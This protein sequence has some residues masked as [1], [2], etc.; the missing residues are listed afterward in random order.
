MNPP[1]PHLW[2]TAAVRGRWMVL[3]PGW[4]TN[5]T[6]ICPYP[7]QKVGTMQ[8]SIVPKLLPLQHWSLFTPKTKINS[9]MKTCRKWKI[10]DGLVY[11]FIT[12][13]APVCPQTNTSMMFKQSKLHTRNI[14]IWINPRTV[15]VKSK[16]KTPSCISLVI[17]IPTDANENN[18]DINISRLQRQTSAS[19]SLRSVKQ[20][21]NV[22]KRSNVSSPS[23]TK[24]YQT[25]SIMPFRT[26]N[27]NFTKKTFIRFPPK[28]YQTTKDDHAGV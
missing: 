4:S 27:D 16:A 15:F 11:I 25:L 19:A 10:E 24:L 7:K 28:W 6:A 3:H 17:Y 9:Y 12:K 1:K 26:Y 18:N 2:R 22:P 21:E 8:D 14:E 5:L 23:F 13:V 20:W